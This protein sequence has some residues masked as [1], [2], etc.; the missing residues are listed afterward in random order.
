[1]DST[2]VPHV[3]YIIDLQQD[4]LFSKYLRFV[5]TVLVLSL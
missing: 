4:T 3:Q 2:V 1:M 5:V